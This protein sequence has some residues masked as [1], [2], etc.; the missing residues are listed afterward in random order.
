M[1][2]ESQFVASWVSNDLFPLI[3]LGLKVDCADHI[4]LSQSEASIFAG[5]V[6]QAPHKAGLAGSPAS[7]KLSHAN[8]PLLVFLVGHN[9]SKYKVGGVGHDDDRRVT[10]VEHLGGIAPAYAAVTI[11]SEEY[12]H[13]LGQATIGAAKVKKTI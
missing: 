3:E 7:G 5:R 10:L 11:L 1:P 2:L 12:S 8:P 13:A 4:C 9:L 6:D